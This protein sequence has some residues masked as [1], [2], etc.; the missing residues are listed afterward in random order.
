MGKRNNYIIQ[1]FLS[2]LYTFSGWEVLTAPLGHFVSILHIKWITRLTSIQR[3]SL[4]K[5]NA[6]SLSHNQI[7][8][9]QNRTTSC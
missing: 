2:Y 3:K 9:M 5:N 8:D 1:N 4:E 7:T 6:M